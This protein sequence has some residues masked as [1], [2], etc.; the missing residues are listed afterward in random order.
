MRKARREDTIAKRMGGDVMAIFG[1][2]HSSTKNIYSSPAS[3]SW[4]RGSKKFESMY[5]IGKRRASWLNSSSA[6]GA[7]NKD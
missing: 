1:G 7:S 5:R 2:W 4:N 3:L 6:R